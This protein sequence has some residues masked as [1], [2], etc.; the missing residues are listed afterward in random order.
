MPEGPCGV[1]DQTGASHV[2]GKCLDPSNQSQHAASF[3]P[4]SSSQIPVGSS[5]SRTRTWWG[6]I[7]APV[8]CQHLSM[9][10]TP[11]PRCTPPKKRPQEDQHTRGVEVWTPRGSAS[12]L[13]WDRAPG[14]RIDIS[15]S[16][17]R[18]TC[19]HWLA[20]GWHSADEPAARH[21]HRS[22]SRGRMAPTWPRN[23]PPV[24]KSQ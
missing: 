14:Y 8:M 11:L 15:P 2:P 18:S 21:H 9:Q 4:F 13:S 24:R 16:R 6:S 3:S 20:Q 5:C 7:R 22:A 12:H 19:P 17:L 10:I 1:S 23:H